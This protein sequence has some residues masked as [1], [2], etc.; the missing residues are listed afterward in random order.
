MFRLLFGPL[1]GV[2]AAAP[3]RSVAV[4]E[5]VAF[6]NPDE[7]VGK[8]W[9]PTLVRAE[10]IVFAAV[11]LIGGRPYQWFRTL[12]AVV[13]VVVALFPRQ[14]VDFGGRLAYESSESL[15][16]KDGFVRAVR[17]LGV[18]FVLAAANRRRGDSE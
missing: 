1:G 17:G 4:Y 7:C 8:P 14:Y 3:E 11:C 10:G 12:T 15:Q 6:E 9:L 18:L 5:R 16:W 2:L 13:G